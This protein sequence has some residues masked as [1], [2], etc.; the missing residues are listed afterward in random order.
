MLSAISK[1]LLIAS[2]LANQCLLSSHA[3]ATNDAGTTDSAPHFH[4]GNGH[5]HHAAEHS[6]SHAG[7][8][9][10]TDCENM[11]V[12]CFLQVPC[13]DHDHDAVYLVNVQ[14]RRGDQGAS[15]FQAVAASTEA[16]QPSVLVSNSLSNSQSPHFIADAPAPARPIY[17]CKQCLRL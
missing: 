9:I 2:L 1:S 8:V 16:L 11:D 13:E 15:S 3:H 12:P 6:H 14:A 7:G 5:S 10:A 17:L 4:V